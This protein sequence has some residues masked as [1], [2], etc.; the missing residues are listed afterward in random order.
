M[1]YIS[2]RFAFHVIDKA[3]GFHKIA[4]KASKDDLVVV[5]REGYYAPLDK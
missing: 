4:L 1:M 3:G 2:L 5:T